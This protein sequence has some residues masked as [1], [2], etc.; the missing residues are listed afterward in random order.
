MTQ[1]GSFTVVYDRNSDVL[2]ITTRRGEPAARGVED[3][4]G[5]VWRYD[6]HNDLIGATVLDFREHWY[7]ESRKPDLVHQLS[8]RFHVPPGQSTALVESGAQEE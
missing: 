8:C 7:Q 6:G 1:I 2:Y 4:A 5:I 3:P